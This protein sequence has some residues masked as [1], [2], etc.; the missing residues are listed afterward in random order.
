MILQV[1]SHDA[2]SDV[3]AVVASEV[4][5]VAVDVV[6]IVDVDDVDVSVVLVVVVMVTSTSWK[7]QRWLPDQKRIS[8][9]SAKARLWMCLLLRCRW[10]TT[11]LKWKEQQKKKATVIFGFFGNFSEVFLWFCGSE[12]REMLITSFEE[13]QLVD[14]S[15]AK[16]LSLAAQGWIMETIWI[17]RV[18]SKLSRY[19]YR[20]MDGL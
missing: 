7:N 13:F 16:F 10:K 5:V 12:R 3:V 4:D 19:G 14:R 1:S 8:N 15:P 20:K 17:S 2:T 9:W 11:L 6:E 18:K